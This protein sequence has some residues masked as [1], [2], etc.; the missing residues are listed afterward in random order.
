M[1]IRH[2]VLA[3]VGVALIGLFLRSIIR[4]ALINRRPDDI[5]L[6]AAGMITSVVFIRMP[7]EP[8]DRRRVDERALWY[9]PISQL[10]LIVIWFGLVVIG[11]ACLYWAAQSVATV[12]EAFLASG[13][14]LSTLGFATPQDAPGQVIAV[15]QGMFGLGVVVFIFTFIPGYL[16]TIQQRDDLVAWV[17]ARTGPS[18]TGAELVDWLVAAGR[19]AEL[20]AVWETWEAWFRSV[21]EAQT[22]SPLVAFDRPVRRHQSWVG[23]SGAMLDAAAFAS[24]SLAVDGR[25][26]AEV[27]VA[28]GAEALEMVEQALARAL[29]RI[30]RDVP[31]PEFDVTGYDALRARLSAAGVALHGDRDAD[32]AAFLALRSRYARTVVRLGRGV[33][34]GHGMARWTLHSRPADTP[35]EATSPEPHAGDQ[36]APGSQTD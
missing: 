8:D 30:P 3:A 25:A 26:A 9:W 32:L 27:C 28:T 13:S 31:V 35:D 14:A 19:T 18:P 36:G 7:A 6:D 20:G 1:D 12:E 10:V 21:G 2:L 34:P 5:L 23:A 33:T 17:Y 22:L 11:F 15:V 24:T 29:R 4:V 16:T